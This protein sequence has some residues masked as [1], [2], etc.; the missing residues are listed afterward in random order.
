MNAMGRN[1]ISSVIGLIAAVGMA[2]AQMTLVTDAS[3]T[4]AQ[5]VIVP[6]YDAES[7]YST[8][9]ILT[10]HGTAATLWAVHFIDS[11]L[12][13]E[14]LACCASNSQTAGVPYVVLDAGSAITLHASSDAYTVTANEGPGACMYPHFPSGGM[15]FIPWPTYDSW[16]LRG[17]VQ[18]I[19]AADTSQVS[20]LQA[21]DCASLPDPGANGSAA[22]TP[23]SGRLTAIAT[24][25]GRLGTAGI[26][27]YGINGFADTGTHFIEPGFPNP[28]LEGSEV[29]AALVNGSAYTFFDPIDAVSAALMTI[30]VSATLASANTHSS[31]LG[32][33]YPTKGYKARS[34]PTTEPFLERFKNDGE[35]CIGVSVAVGASAPISS[36][37]E[38]YLVTN[39]FELLPPGVSLDGR[40]LLYRFMESNRIEKPL[41]TIVAAPGSHNVQLDYAIDFAG[42]TQGVLYSTDVPLYGEPALPFVL[43]FQNPTPD[44]IFSTGPVSVLVN[45]IMP[46]VYVQLADSFG[47]V[48]TSSTAPVTLALGT[49]AGGATLGGTKTVNAVAGVATFNGLTL[50]KYGMGYQLAASSEGAATSTSNAFSVQAKL[51]FTT[52]P[53]NAVAGQTM[54]ADVTVQMLDANDNAVSGTPPITLTANPAGTLLGGTTSTNAVN[55]LATFSALTLYA[56]GNGFTLTA[57]GPGLISAT[58]MAFNLAPGPPD[59]L[60]FFSQ[61]GT[62]TVDFA[63]TPPVEVKVADANGNQ[64]TN[65]GSV[66]LAFGTNPAGATLSGT[67][68]INAV[69]GIA[70][71]GNLV[72]DKP[73]TGYTLSASTAGLTGVTSSAFNVVNDGIFANGFDGP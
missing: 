22:L 33:T 64:T 48:I 53:T 49:N 6:F 27:T 67:K 12:G 61:P 59:H 29:N 32:I 7:S 55:G 73:G 63:M 66:T 37:C 46:T 40:D 52:Q 47:N 19:P 15:P 58:S 38:Q 70:T 62:A 17:H 42:G 34:S 51:T 11:E 25:S 2:H 36:T 54:S 18:F 39:L 43:T 69:S 65:T 35:S 5:V 28:G 72:I 41:T 20:S 14:T 50:D 23:P 45:A 9:I 44:L 71:F 13:D 30:Q 56:A 57:T 4:P 31:Y 60:E 1:A 10:N 16:P 24:V 68:T 8:D 26:S 3:T 21:G